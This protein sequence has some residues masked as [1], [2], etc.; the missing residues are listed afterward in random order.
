[1]FVVNLTA[2]VDRIIPQQVKHT[3]A[4]HMHDYYYN[5]NNITAIS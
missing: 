2:A 1:M 3:G 4:E 5:N